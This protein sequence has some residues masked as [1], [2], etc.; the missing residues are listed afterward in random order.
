MSSEENTQQVLQELIKY[1][2]NLM[3]GMTPDDKLK[4]LKNSDARKQLFEEKPE[5]FLPIK[6]MDNGEF[7][8]FFVICNRAG[9]TDPDMI[10]SAMKLC[11]KMMN[12]DSVSQ[13]E[14]V[15]TLKKLIYMYKDQTGGLNKSGSM[16]YLKGKSTKRLNS[17]LNGLQS[18]IIKK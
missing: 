17:V 10:R 4:W 16:A 6:R 12:K 8:P 3:T 2:D 13:I 5:C 18:R 15:K 1:A 14:L 11:K 7:Q 9:G